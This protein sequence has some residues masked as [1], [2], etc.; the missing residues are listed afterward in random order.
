MDVATSL[1]EIYQ[2]NE[3]NP[4]FS[5][6]KEREKYIYIPRCTVKRGC[7]H[8][9]E[10]LS[11]SWWFFYH[12]GCSNHFLLSLFLFFKAGF[13]I[14]NRRIFRRFNFTNDTLLYLFFYFG[15]CRR[16]KVYGKRVEKGSWRNLVV[17][18]NFIRV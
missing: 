13:P 16:W 17:H 5:R 18:R 4:F 9:G 2:P 12:G 11:N 15:N 10:F 14:Y 6:L 1:L 7:N 8:S 3:G